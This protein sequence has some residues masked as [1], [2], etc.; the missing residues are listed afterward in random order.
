[1]QEVIGTIQILAARST[2]TF[3]SHLIRGD[4][5]M[6]LKLRA[7][8]APNGRA[9]H[10]DQGTVST[11]TGSTSFEFEILRISV[12][13]LRQV[14]SQQMPPF[15]LL[16]FIEFRVTPSYAPSYMAIH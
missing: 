13:D 3:G 11:T 5:G 12:I 16:P 14:I 9:F 8:Y 1:M 15:K 6:D 2:G 10:V 7:A 4:P